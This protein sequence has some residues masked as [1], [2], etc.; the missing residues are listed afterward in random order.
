MSKPPIIDR[1]RPTTFSDFLIYFIFVGVE[2]W[3]KRMPIVV[4]RLHL[5][6]SFFTNAQYVWFLLLFYEIKCMVH[7]TVQKQERSHHQI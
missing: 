3:K 6:Y 5:Q 4:L 1:E 2:M 7:H